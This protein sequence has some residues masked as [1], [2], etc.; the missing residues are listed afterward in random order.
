MDPEISV[1]IPTY[2]RS[3]VLERALE[4]LY[5]QTL[6]KDRFEIVVV[7]DGSMDDTADVAR[8]WARQAS[9]RTLFLHQS[10]RGANAARN[11]ALGQ[12]RGRL[13]LFINDDTIAVPALLEEHL[14]S[15]GREP[16]EPVAVLG[17]MTLAPEI[18]P[19][20]LTDIHLDSCFNLIDGRFEL[21]WK[22]FF[23]CN[24]SVKRTFLM[25]HG[26]FE[27]GLRW[28]EDLELASR[29]RPHGLRVVYNPAAL[30][31][32]LH[33]LSEEGFLNMARLE[34]EALVTW[35]R[36][37]PQL[38]DDLAELGLTVLQPLPDRIRYWFGD[39][40]TNPRGFPH[41]LRLARWLDDRNLR[42]SR[43]L[44]RKLYQST[45]RRT[46]YRAMKH[47]PTARA[48]EGRVS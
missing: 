45:K 43:M 16:A 5:A 8:A 22:W 26:R 30:A 6:A 29:L 9:P 15:H 36:K 37:A 44:Y 12:A 7:N 24:V 1:I 47:Q 35:Y 28:H 17:R 18:Q 31:H 42:L 4:A 39:A 14:G 41:L 33:S 13:L 11:L 21:D 32:H 2:N 19:S 20:A 23:T 46:I 3:R 34:G 40:L 27:E 48:H 10:N 25:A 38:R